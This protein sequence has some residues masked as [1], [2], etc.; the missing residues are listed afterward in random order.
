[1]ISMGLKQKIIIGYFTDGKS[2]RKLAKEFKLHRKTVCRYI[3]EHKVLLA[4]RAVTGDIPD[5]GII[6]PPRYQSQGRV[7][8]VLTEEVS[9]RIDH[10]L[11]INA[12]R[13]LQGLHKQ[14]EV[15]LREIFWARGKLINKARQA[16]ANFILKSA[17]IFVFFRIKYG[18]PLVGGSHPPP[19]PAT[20]PILGGFYWARQ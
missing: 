6:E 14:L 3:E 2:R 7:R 9:A 20:H 5:G 19:P 18:T 10:Y 17:N 1:M 8:V 11:N 16:K 15:R 12:V 13:R 4:E